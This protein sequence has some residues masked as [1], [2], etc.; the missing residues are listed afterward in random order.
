MVWLSVAG[1]L[2]RVTV[3]CTYCTRDGL[4]S[5]V[6]MMLDFFS[7]GEPDAVWTTDLNGSDEANLS[8]TLG[9]L[10]LSLAQ[11]GASSVSEVGTG[12]LVWQAGPALAK[13]LALYRGGSLSA[14][15]AGGR[16]IELGC[17]CSALPGIALAL[18]GAS[19]V[20]V[21]DSAAVLS[22]LQPNLDGYF[23]TDDD[24]RSASTAMIAAGSRRPLR[25]LVTTKPIGWDSVAS[26]AALAEHPRG[27]SLVVAADCDYADTLHSM[28]IDAVTAALHPSPDSVALFAT[29]A[30]CQR[31]LR[32]FLSRLAE[33]KF[34]V[35]ELGDELQ[36]LTHSE[37]SARGSSYDGVRY[38]AARWRDEQE[39][40]AARA[41]FA[42]AGAPTVTTGARPHMASPAPAAAVAVP[43]APN[44]PAVSAVDAA[45]DAVDA[46]F[47]EMEEAMGA[48][49]PTELRGVPTATAPPTSQ[50]VRPPDVS[51]VGQVAPEDD[52]SDWTPVGPAATA[53]FLAKCA[54]T[55]DRF[56]YPCNAKHRDKPARCAYSFR[57]IKAPTTKTGGKQQQLPCTEDK[58]LIS[59]RLAECEYSEGGT[60]WRVWPCALLLS[61]WLV[62]REA[63]LR[64][65][66]RRTRALELGCGLGLPGLTAA[67]LGAEISVLSDCLPAL[68]EAIHVSVRANREGGV[69]IH[70]TATTSTA[71]SGN[72]FAGVRVACLDW[73]DAA[74]VHS[75]RDEEFSTEQGVKAA[76]LAKQRAQQRVDAGSEAVNV[77]AAPLDTRERFGLV[78]ASDVIYSLTHATQ[79]PEVISQRLAHDSPSS[80][81]AAMVPVRSTPHTRTFLEGLASHGMRV[82][83]SRVDSAWVAA[84]VAPQRTAPE[85]AAEA[86]I[87]IGEPFNGRE[88]TLTEGEILFVEAT[89]D[90]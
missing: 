86:T 85:K 44:N 71:A 80:L 45:L 77:V 19:E 9:D 87:P 65:D 70:R 34:D 41:R 52:S 66:E 4:V 54:K 12:A 18:L 48:L 30:R 26:L 35:C 75:L 47:A 21:S 82:Q 42:S 11:P 84:V 20:I 69:G 76:Q 88:T 39:A 32:L 3:L 24:C 33:R 25:E 23:A 15:I 40:R 68:L 22:Q 67:A 81:L 61:C 28:L 73:D 2:R 17:G 31:T 8:V 55:P 7:D 5:I 64:L 49:D 83:I 74:P 16:T 50:P 89:R 43:P 79:L 38:F 36:P 29:A 90:N 53:A 56:F 14:Q 57:R 37:S 63:T 27:C 62:A 13:S 58:A 1:L 78:L 46:A 10:T 72:A 60:G 51:D 59:V 6:T